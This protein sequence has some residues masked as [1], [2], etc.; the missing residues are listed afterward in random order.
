MIRPLFR[1]LNR[2]GKL[3]LGEDLSGF[4]VGPDA[5]SINAEILLNKVTSD[6]RK[7]GK[8]ADE[9]KEVAFS[10]AFPITQA[11]QKADRFLH[12]EGVLESEG[13]AQPLEGYAPEITEADELE[14]NFLDADEV[15]GELQFE[16]YSPDFIDDSDPEH[17]MDGG[18]DI[19]AFVPRLATPQIHNLMRGRPSDIEESIARQMV[20][21]PFF[22]DRYWLRRKYLPAACFYMRGIIDDE[23]LFN[24]VWEDAY[25]DGRLHKRGKEFDFTEY[26]EN[27]KDLKQLIESY[28]KKYFIKTPALIKATRIYLQSIGEYTP[29]NA[30]EYL[31]SFLKRYKTAWGSLSAKQRHAIEYKYLDEETLENQE[32]AD[33]FQISKDSLIDRINS[34]KNIFRKAFPEL[35]GLKPEGKRSKIETQ[36][37]Y[38]GLFWKADASVIHPLFKFDPIKKER[39]EIEPP[40]VKSKDKARNNTDYIIDVEAD[41]K[42][43]ITVPDLLDTEFFDGNFPEN[44]FARIGGHSL[45]MGGN[46]HKQLKHAERGLQRNPFADDSYIQEKELIPVVIDEP[47]E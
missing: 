11:N 6:L 29:E 47:E 1:K 18:D 3:H 43:G 5:N 17:D 34:A 13:R 26:Q 23:A 19:L 32:S 4:S 33:K 44:Y 14:A 37:I 20:E 35:K 41:S 8:W 40:L 2:D 38:G 31:E 12:N 45:Y 22:Y 25:K 28:S 10:E 7:E 42:V 39:V 9:D 30:K 15:S 24:L 46:L 21:G 27:L 36:S 16:D